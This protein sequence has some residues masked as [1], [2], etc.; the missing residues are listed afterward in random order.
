MITADK[1]TSPIDVDDNKISAFPAARPRQ[2]RGRFM[3]QSPH[4]SMNAR[5]PQHHGLQHLA[6]GKRPHLSPK[7]ADPES[8]VQVVTLVGLLVGFCP[9]SSSSPSLESPSPRRSLRR[10]L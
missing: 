1:P 5:N 10:R 3:S 2:K 7:A 6:H 8:S 9:S 4:V